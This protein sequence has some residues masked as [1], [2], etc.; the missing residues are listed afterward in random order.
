MTSVNASSRN[1]GTPLVVS[2]A[3]LSVC[4]GYAWRHAK[5]VRTEQYGTTVERVRGSQWMGSGASTW[6]LPVDGMVPNS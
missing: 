2:A 3:L 5:I 1:M 4:R 6:L